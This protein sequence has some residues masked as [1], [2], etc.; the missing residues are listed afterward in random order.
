[1]K[2]RRLSILRIVLATCALGLS[3][4]LGFARV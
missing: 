2:P 3:W 4:L 1:M